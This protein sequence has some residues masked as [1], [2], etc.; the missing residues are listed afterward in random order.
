MRFRLA[1]ATYTAF[2][3]SLIAYKV[4]RTFNNH[5]ER[6]ERD[7]DERGLAYLLIRDSVLYGF[8]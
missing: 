4:T 2:L 1:W 3:L 6:V 7:L 5:D 8:M